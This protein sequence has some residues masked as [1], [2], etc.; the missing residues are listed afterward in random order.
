MLGAFTE[1]CVQLQWKEA[2]RHEA[3][4]D[5]TAGAGMKTV[6]VELNRLAA[7]SKFDEWAADVAV[8]PGAQWTRERQ[9]AAGC[10]RS[11]LCPR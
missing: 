10:A 9:I 4:E 11:P 1:H 6:Q 2:A 8:I 5:L 7:Q 3:G